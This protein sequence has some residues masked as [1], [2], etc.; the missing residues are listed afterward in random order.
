[1]RTI[2]SLMG[3]NGKN[4]SARCQGG[5]SPRFR[6]TGLPWV[7]CLLFLGTTGQ[8]ESDYLE[9]STGVF[10]TS[11]RNPALEVA[12]ARPPLPA[13]PLSFIENRGQW[14]EAVRFVT[15]RGPTVALFEDNT[16]TL[17]LW[18]R[19]TGEAGAVGTQIR[20]CFEG[21]DTASMEGEGRQPTK[22]NFILGNDP[23]K[24]RRAVPSYGSIL[25][26]GLYPRI[27]LRARESR[28]GR[29]GFIAYDLVVS[30]GADPSQFVVRCEGIEDLEI[31]PDGSLLLHAEHGVLRQTRP[32]AWQRM[33]EGGRRSV[34]CEFRVLDQISYGF[35]VHDYDASTD[36]LI[37][38]T[39]TWSTFLGGSLVDACLAVASHGNEIL[40]AGKA[41]AGFPTCG[42]CFDL[43]HN[44]MWDG[45]VIKLNA[46]GGACLWSTFIGGSNDES[47]RSMVVTATGEVVVAGWTKSNDFPIPPDLVDP[48]VRV[49]DHEFGG[50]YDAFLLK[51]SETGDEVLY[52]TFLGGPSE[53]VSKDSDATEGITDMAPYRDDAVC[54]TGF[55]LSE[56]FPTTLDA[57]QPQKR[58]EP[59]G[60][61]CDRYDAFVC[62]VMPDPDLPR[63]EQ[64]AFSSYLGGTRN[65]AHGTKFWNRQ[66]SCDIAASEEGMIAVAGI[67]NS[68]AGPDSFPITRNALQPVP[69]GGWDGFLT[70]ID[71]FPDPG[72]DQVV[73]STYLGGTSADYPETIA[74]RDARTVYVAGCTFSGRAD[75]FPVTLNAFQGEAYVV[76]PDKPDGFLTIMDFMDWLEPT[77]LHSTFIGHTEYDEILD[78]IVNDAG[79]VTLV[80]KTRSPGFP[81]TPDAFQEQHASPIDHNDAFLLRLHPNLHPDNPDPEPQLLYGTFLGG[82]GGERIEAVAHIGQ[83]NV[84]V[85]G[86]TGETFPITPGAFQEVA[87]GSNDGFVARFSFCHEVTFRRGDANTDSAIDIADAI[88]IFRYLFAEGPAPSCLDAADANDDGAVNISD[89]VYILQNLFANGPAI[90]PPYPECG[91]D[92]TEDELGCVEYPHCE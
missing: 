33:P 4:H 9:A 21:A 85:A 71:P 26:K 38:P 73:Y 68:S 75:G 92:P 63:E 15:R 80:G 11:I 5:S 12:A 7:A 72:K 45:F 52:S 77:L 47:I 70:L 23:S 32:L 43:T 86:G 79:E 69:M 24:W 62:V 53:G 88:F 91:I 54:V 66:R 40:V 46:E 78:M 14:R 20:M 55:T 30:A 17:Q 57:F 34:E 84:V 27:D 56:G 6:G 18:G 89:G 87:G 2:V 74:F 65:E 19:R 83:C 42:D 90:P 61:G 51:L 22:T 64:L 39:L 82:V 49:F 50:N 81:V 3:M 8:A 37:D 76:S 60:N 44:G 58:G 1:M 28:G 31:A 13:L 36:L 48:I 10:R 29:P 35:H 41:E 59:D 25:Y 16:I 67:T